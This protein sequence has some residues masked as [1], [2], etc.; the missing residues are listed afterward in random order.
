MTHMTPALVNALNQIEQDWNATGKFKVP[1]GLNIFEAL[2]NESFQRG[3]KN[4]G[5]VVPPHFAQ[6]NEEDILPVG[7]LSRD[8]TAAILTLLNYE[9]KRSR[10]RKLQDLGITTAQFNG[11]M[12][13]PKF[14][15]YYMDLAEKQFKDALPVAQE[16]IIKSMEKGSVEAIKFYMEITGRHTGDTAGMQNVKIIIAKLVE[17]IQMHVKDP[18]ALE[19]IAT[20]FDNILKGGSPQP[21]KELESRI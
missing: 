20:D 13:D 17:S 18:V 1:A 21:L 3:L 12:K 9:D 7:Y 11:W 8:Q 6:E 15:D 5:I 14:K 19:A 4:R 10:A 16:S 2:D